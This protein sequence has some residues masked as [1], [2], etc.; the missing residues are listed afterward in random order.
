M[1]RS[2]VTHPHL[3]ALAALVA[4]ALAALFLPFA[5]GPAAA[6]GTYDGF[7]IDGNI[8]SDGATDWAT[9]TPGG[10]ILNDNAPETTVF[11]TSSKESA[12]TT[13]QAPTD[14]AGTPAQWTDGNDSAPGKTD[15]T[16][17][18]RY[19]K[20]SAAGEVELFF[21]WERGKDQGTLYYYL[22]LN[23]KP[24]VDQSGLSVPQR[25]AGDYRFTLEDKGN[26]ELALAHTDTWD[27]KWVM[28]ANDPTGFDG[29]VNTIDIDRP[30]GF[31]AGES[32]IPADTFAEAYFNL[33]VL[34][35][36]FGPDCPP[37]LGTLNFRSS[38]G[39]TGHDAGDN[40]KDYI[41]PQALGAP[42]TCGRM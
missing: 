25:T 5:A 39:L 1:I 24:N 42:N 15:I 32:L 18:Y 12:G 6:V 29:A 17:V 8:V 40:L 22:E 20:T 13:P 9:A 27:G 33:S 10:P 7:E 21:A 4:V 36:D 41:L 19:T 16:N 2:P 31:G 34:I 35:P 3:R 37:P 11:Q 26:G 38:T 14:G 30:D 23:A 28:V